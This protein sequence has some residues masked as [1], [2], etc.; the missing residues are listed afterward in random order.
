MSSLV[1]FDHPKNF[2]KSRNVFCE[3]ST[4]DFFSGNLLDQEVGGREDEGDEVLEAV[5]KL[6]DFDVLQLALEVVA[7]CD[8]CA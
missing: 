3:F 2:N 4:R 7:C 8:R 1:M 5:L 6:L